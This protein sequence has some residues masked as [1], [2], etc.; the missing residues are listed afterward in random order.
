LKQFF[1]ILAVIGYVV[2]FAILLLPSLSM[3]LPT[4][5]YCGMAVCALVAVVCGSGGRRG[6]A[7][8][9]LV[10]ALT[11][12]IHAWHHNR[13][14]LASMRQLARESNQKLKELEAQEQAHTN[15]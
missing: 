13:R 3:F 7:V 4:E 8:V 14:V 12:G 5:A 15:R 9:G 10:F 2:F 1:F 6:L 11:G